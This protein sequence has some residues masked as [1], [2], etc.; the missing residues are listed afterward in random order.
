MYCKCNVWWLAELD[1]VNKVPSSFPNKCFNAFINV[2][3]VFS[4]FISVKESAMILLQTVPTHI[5]VKHLQDKLL[6]KV[7]PGFY[8]LEFSIPMFQPFNQD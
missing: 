2:S 3:I 8:Q 6:E 4:F 5:Q 7:G 1:P